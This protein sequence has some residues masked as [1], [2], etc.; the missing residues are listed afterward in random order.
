MVMNSP[1][2]KAFRHFPVCNSIDSITDA[3]QVCFEKISF[4]DYILFFPFE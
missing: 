1:E 3:F 4:G 2:R